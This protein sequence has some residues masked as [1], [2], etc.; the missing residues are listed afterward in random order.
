MDY[1]RLALAAIAAFV[2]DAAYGF[3]VWGNLLKADFERYPAVFRAEADVMGLMPM[4]FAGILLGMF[5]LAWIYAKGYEGG[6][7]VAEGARFGAVVGLMMIA[8]FS[9]G[10]YATTNIGGTFAAKSAVASFIE[11]LIVGVTLGAV[12]RPAAPRLTPGV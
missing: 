5:A 7:G 4:M 10:M 2:V 8:F 12:Y 9:I 3:V 1:R 6:S 11:M